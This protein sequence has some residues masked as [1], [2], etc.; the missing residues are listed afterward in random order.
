MQSILSLREEDRQR[1]RYRLHQEMFPLC[2]DAIG[3][4]IEKGSR[5]NDSAITRKMGLS[6][7]KARYVSWI[8]NSHPVL[9]LSIVQYRRA[10]SSNNRDSLK[11]QYVFETQAGRRVR[12]AREAALRRI[13]EIKANRDPLLPRLT[14]AE[15]RV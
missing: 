2:L 1:R 15:V 6:R 11:K 7:S 10:L 5:I 14:R 3:A 9:G 4:L 13:E 12:E 8:W